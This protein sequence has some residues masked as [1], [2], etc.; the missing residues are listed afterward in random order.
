[1]LESLR[2]LSY[3]KG[4]TPTGVCP[5]LLATEESVSTTS[6]AVDPGVEFEPSPADEDE[7]STA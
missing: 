2:R 4:Q 3:P 7:T 5:S 6:Y 1:V